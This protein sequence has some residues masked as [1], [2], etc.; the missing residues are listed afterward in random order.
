MKDEYQSLLSSLKDPELIL[1]KKRAIKQYF[2]TQFCSLEIRIAILGGSTTAEVR[3][4]IEIFLLKEGICPTFYESGYNQYYEEVMFHDSNLLLF[5][6]DV[7]YIHTSSVNIS[8]F[9][10]VN[11]SEEQVHNLLQDEF[12]KFRDIWEAAFKKFNCTI[13][14]NNFEL[15][16][17]RV[18]GNL[19]CTDLRGRVSYIT[20][21]NQRFIQYS[22]VDRRL[23]IND[24]HY[25]AASIGLDR[26][27]D[28]RLWFTSK[29]ALSLE[30]IPLLAHQI[31]VII[32]ATLGKSKKCI[33]LD[34]DNTLWG[35]VIADDGLAGI[36][37]GNGT[38]VAEAYSAFQH[39]LKQLH[40]RG[41]LLAIC[42]KNDLENALE[43]FK[44][45]DMVLKVENFSLF[46]ANWES[47]PAN[48]RKIAEKLC[49][50][51]DSIVFVDD[52]SVER[53]HV[54]NSLS[55]TTVVELSEDISDYIKNIDSMLLFEISTLSSEDLNRNHYY[56]MNQKRENEKNAYDSLKDF[57]K[58][59]RMVA[60]IEP[61]RDIYL[62][63]ITQL[64]NKTN[65]FNLTTR[66]HTFAEV[67][68][69]ALDEQY[70]TLYGKLE[71]KIGQNGIVS[72]IIGKQYQSIMHID[73]WVMSC[74]VFQ[75]GMEAAMLDQ[76]I[77]Y[78]IR[79]GVRKIYG[80]Y[81]KTEKNSIVKN[82]YQEF[83]FEL[84]KSDEFGNTEWLLDVSDYNCIHNHIIEV[85]Q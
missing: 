38:P 44:H 54:K 19:D 20:A 33:V 74:R 67:S 41:I 53:E 76:F 79:K 58:S 52:N 48:I 18:L 29:Y 5:K 63:R 2:S 40:E 37:I 27:Y 9:P 26:W 10:D 49:L 60:E 13:I 70:L 11:D 15:P 25:L 31:A 69:I 83:D 84:V 72:A 32:G 34:L 42:S 43:G 16:S 39:Y 55:K 77:K 61:F 4:I 14:Q 75:R 22:R 1:R 82:L 78:A 81:Y 80:I 68:S 57:L 64:I 46:I 8:R 12:Q 59:L 6:P 45:P 23:V 66:R 71:D 21:L 85:K 28:A 56:E 24:I 7:I 30:A 50:S 36:Q 62:D 17:F 73:L 35:G 65:Q 3:D 51:V 47:K